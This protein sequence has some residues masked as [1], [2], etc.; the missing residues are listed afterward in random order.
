MDKKQIKEFKNYLADKLGFSLNEVKNT[1]EL[2]VDLGM[3]DLDFIEI[4]MDCE[5][6][7]NIVIVDEKADTCITVSDFVEMLKTCRIRK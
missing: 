6:K 4:I 3:D 1:S 7:F 5:V 2:A